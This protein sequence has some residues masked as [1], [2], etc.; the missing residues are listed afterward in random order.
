MTEV[1]SHYCERSK[2]VKMSKCAKRSSDC[3]HLFACTACKDGSKHLFPDDV[4]NCLECAE[5]H[6]LVDAG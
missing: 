4:T 6:V 1:V 2:E 5:G 3:S